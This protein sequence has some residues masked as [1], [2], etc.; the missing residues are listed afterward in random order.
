[1][2]DLK[3]LTRGNVEF[4]GAGGPLME[5]EGLSSPLY[6]TNI[7][8]H[9]PFVPFRSTYVEENNWWLWLKHNPITKKYTRPMHKVL[10]QRN[11]IVEAI[12]HH[13]PQTIVTLDHDILSWKLHRQI[14]ELYA[15]ASTPRPK[16]V[17]LSRF[18][19]RYNISHTEYIDHVLYTIPI[20]PNN[21]NKFKISSTYIGQDSF[22]RAYRFLLSRSSEGKD[23]LEDDAVWMHRTHFYAEVEPFIVAERTRFREKH[24]IKAQET[25]LFF[26]PGSNLEEVAWTLPHLI[27]TANLFAQTYEVV[28][29]QHVIVL[30]TTP[31]IKSKV[32]KAVNE[33]K[34][35]KNTR[36]IILETEE[37]KYSALAGSDLGIVYNG[38]IAGE[39]LANQL[40]TV[41]IQNMTKIEFYVMTSWNRFI[42]DMNIT[43]DGP[44]YPEIIEG[45]CH[46]P[47]LVE[48]IGEWYT[49]P[50]AR[51]WPLQGFEPHL[52]RFLPMKMRETG[53][54]MHNLYYSPRALTA[55]KVWELTQQVPERTSASKE[56]L[57]YQQV[58]A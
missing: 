34:W 1:M 32:Q 58:K 26:A 21:F 29:G 4:I 47:K 2:A 52:N 53:M 45:Q 12:F 23:L 33:A 55:K 6:K 46:P 40:S 56:N 5:A 13:H 17:H 44:L 20:E 41:V 38:E 16:Q 35:H 15:T 8:A 30:P 19:N 10:S 3:Q 42:N 18:V 39:C 28:D 36:V 24:Q 54:G 48:V 14:K 9:K 11:Q 57:F 49:S 31:A 22:Y 7:F 43:A 51:F 37:D 27:G 25:V 50:P